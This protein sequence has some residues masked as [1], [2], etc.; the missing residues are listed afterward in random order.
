MHQRTKEGIET[1]RRKGKQ[2]GQRAGKSLTTKKGII[3]KQGIQKYSKDFG[4]SLNDAE[5]MKLLGISR[6]TFYKYK[7]QLKDGA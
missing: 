5:C 2:I 6:N 4:G 3:A 7:G 1:A